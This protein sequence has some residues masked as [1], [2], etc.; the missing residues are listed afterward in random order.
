MSPLESAARLADDLLFPSALEV[1]RADRVPVSHFEA[2][3]R[4]G[5]YGFDG[6]LRIV[7]VLASG[8]LATAFVWLQHFGPLASTAR[9]HPDLHAALAGGRLKGGIARAGARPGTRSLTVSSTVDGY[10]LDG[11]VPWVTGW[12]MI[13]I[14]E[15]AALDAGDNVVFLLVDAHDSPTLTSR[16]NQLVA[17]NASRTVTLTFTG[18]RA[19]ADRLVRKQPLQE[20]QA[21]E[22]PGSRLNGGL[23]LGVAARCIRLLGTEILDTET[24]LQSELD[25]CRRALL[26]A[27]AS[28][29]PRARAAASELAMRAATTLTVHTGSRSVLLDDHAQRLVREAAFLLVFGTRERIKNELLKAL[30]IP[31]GQLSPRW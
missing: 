6:D 3:A 11:P 28:T 2:L 25:A 15:V 19:A 5:L 9:R 23:A 18:H 30:S 14:V 8:C 27:D 12:G 10:V 22:A 29:L 20:W 26:E 4:E 24:P 13:D 1:D 21:A 17:V 31:L 16:L 7:E